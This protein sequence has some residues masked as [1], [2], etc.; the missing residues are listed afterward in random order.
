M[1]LDSA[2]EDDPRSIR[3]A[4]IRAESGIR[5]IGQ[6]CYLVTFLCGLCTIVCILVAIGVMDHAHELDETLSPEIIRLIYWVCSAVMLLS[7][8]G[9]WAVGYGLTHLRSWARWTVVA[10]T[11]ASLISGLGFGVG[12]CLA[13][14]AWGLLGLLIVVALH[15]MILYP[16]LTP[17][18]GVVCSRQ[19]KEVIRATP[20]IRSRMHWLLK[21]LIGLIVAGVVGIVGYLIGIY[22]R[23]IEP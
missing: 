23:L 16:L 4:H 2:R 8:L 9:H 14:P 1:T 20:D 7:A 15:A 6:L 10:L 5:S 21:L 12:L 17:G 13:Y 3:L 19:Y 11:G 22:L 18:A